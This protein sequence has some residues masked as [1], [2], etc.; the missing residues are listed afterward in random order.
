MDHAAAIVA[1]RELIELAD[2]AQ[3]LSKTR[4]LEFRI[5]T[6]EVVSTELRRHRH[7]ARQEPAAQWSVCEGRHRVR[8]AI[9]Q[10]I[11]FAIALKQIV[12]RLSG[13]K[14]RD[15]AKGIHLL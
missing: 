13:V 8:S 9:R 6:P 1:F 11:C 5:V 7:A 2:R 4:H 15:C 3:V 10:H 14:R 12:R